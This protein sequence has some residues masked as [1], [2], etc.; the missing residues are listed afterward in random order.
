ML[1]VQLLADH[2]GSIAFPFSATP[3]GCIWALEQSLQRPEQEAE[4]FPSPVYLSDGCGLVAK[5][6][7]SL[8]TVK[9]GLVRQ[10]G[11]TGG[12]QRQEEGGDVGG[13]KGRKHP[14]VATREN[15]CN[16][17]FGTWETLTSRAPGMGGTDV[18]RTVHSVSEPETGWSL[19]E[20][21]PICLISKGRKLPRPGLTRVGLCACPELW[22]PPSTQDG[23][24]CPVAR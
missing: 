19:Q 14:E 8:A 4:A 1:H 10:A 12:A 11:E 20:D 5:E 6:A 13:E 18:L 21:F 2:Q 3:E 15:P 22:P 16:K 23:T 17:P 24:C 9:Q 7:V